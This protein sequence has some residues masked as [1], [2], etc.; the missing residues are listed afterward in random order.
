MTTIAA[1]NPSAHSAYKAGALAFLLAL[2]T[3]LGALAF[4][5][6]GKYAP[7]PL[8]LEQRYAY[9][10][11]VPL[12]FVALVLLSSG[13]NR[14]AALVFGLVAL[15]FLA[16]AALGVYHAGAEWRFWPGPD[17]CTGAQGI[18]TSAGNLLETLKETTVVRCDEP[19][20]RILGVS[21]AGWNAVVSFVL[22]VLSARA[23]AES[24]RPE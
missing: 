3:I 20:L 19:A 17:S 23:T 11:S 18:T 12:L 2:A 10:A 21:L 1:P 4:E 16:N 5:Y 22:F 24:L 14:T 15:A 13:V 7:C 8:C 6:I 9:Y